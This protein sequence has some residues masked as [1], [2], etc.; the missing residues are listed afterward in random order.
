MA[1]FVGLDVSLNEVSVCIMDTDGR[2]IAR[3]TI[4]CD[5]SSIVDFIGKH[6]RRVSRIVHESGQL[7]TWLHRELEALGAPIVCVDA[8]T[9]KKA[10]SARLNKSDSV[11]A[12]GLAQLRRRRGASRPGRR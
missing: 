7:S 6:S 10:L 2:V 9:A 11:D 5:P 12:E 1:D 4:P 8:R 3:G